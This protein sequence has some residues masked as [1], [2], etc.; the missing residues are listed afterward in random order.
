MANLRVYLNG[1]MFVLSRD[2]VLTM[3]DFSNW[4]VATFKLPGKASDYVLTAHYRVH[5]MEFETTLYPHNA[6]ERNGEV[7]M[8]NGLWSFRFIL[9]EEDNCRAC[10]A[11]C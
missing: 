1:C 7:E 4:A 5:R 2:V 3:K 8:R 6:L 9:V 11:I 10:C